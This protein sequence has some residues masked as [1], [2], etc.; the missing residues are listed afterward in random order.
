[1]ARFVSGIAY[2]ICSV[3]LYVVLCLQMM[4]SMGNF[5]GGGPD[6]GEGVS[7]LFTTSL[8]LTLVAVSV[9]TGSPHPGLLVAYF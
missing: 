2:Y 9:S 4:R 5:N 1:M 7:L 8:L 3:Y 6:M